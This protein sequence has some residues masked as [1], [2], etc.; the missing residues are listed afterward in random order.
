MIR[1][2]ARAL[3]RRSK[4]TVTALAITL[5]ILLG[6]VDIMTGVE[7]HFLLLYLV[8]IFLA[9]WFVSREV[10]VYLAL[11]ASLVWFIADS[12]GGRSYSSEW[13]SYWNLLMRTGA[14]TAFAVIQAQLRARL[15]ELGN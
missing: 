3:E 2:L 8:P 7:I 6:Y 12:L 5:T 11:F 4:R 13:I 10:G 14:F 1:K 15:D 9:S